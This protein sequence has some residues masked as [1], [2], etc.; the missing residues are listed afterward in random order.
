[1]TFYQGSIDSEQETPPYS[2]DEREKHEKVDLEILGG[3]TR[4]EKTRLYGSLR[5]S[6]A[7]SFPLESFPFFFKKSN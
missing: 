2:T 3:I 6:T 1:M 4:S 5:K 7:E